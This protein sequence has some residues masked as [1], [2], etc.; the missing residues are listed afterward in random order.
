MTTLLVT[1]PGDGATRF[2]RDYYVREHLP[3]VLR[4]WGPHGLQSCTAFFPAEECDGTIALALCEF[5]DEASLQSAL[6]APDTPKVMA[7][8]PRFTDTQPQQRRATAL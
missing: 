7:D 4:A 3:L 5:R 8:V 6:A 2:D 1:Y